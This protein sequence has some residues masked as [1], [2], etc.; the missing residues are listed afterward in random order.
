MPNIDK[1][2]IR[3]EVKLGNYLIVRTPYV[4]SFNIKRARGQMC[5]TFSAS[6]KVDYE[7]FAASRDL[8]ADR[9]IIKA[10]TGTGF[11]NL[12]ILFT[13]K[14]YKCVINPVRTDA[15]KVI[16]NISGK[17]VLSIM[18][19]QKI[20]RRLKMYRDGSTPP[21]RWGI[22]NNVVKHNTPKRKSFP[23]KVYTNSKIGVFNME[24]RGVI[25]TPDAYKLENYV[26]RSRTGK[27]FGGTSA[28]KIIE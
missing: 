7:E 18:E 4:L 15:S 27:V 17:D 13:G 9:I 25:E 22:I 24:K 1:Q 21:Q 2:S 26:K 10:G 23:Q 28:E 12:P 11:T 6:L 19:N 8:L 14:I 5:A 20:N 3:A 16:L